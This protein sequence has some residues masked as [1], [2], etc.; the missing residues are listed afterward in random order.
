MTDIDTTAAD[1]PVEDAVAAQ[2]A[3]AEVSPDD[4]ATEAAE[5]RTA[6]E[7]AALRG[8]TDPDDIAAGV[9]QNYADETG[10]EAADAEPAEGTQADAQAAPAD[11]AESGEGTADAKPA[12]PRRARK[13]KAT[14]APPAG[15][16]T[17]P[18]APPAPAVDDSAGRPLTKDEKRALAAAVVTA[19]AA[20]LFGARTPAALKG[21]PS[22]TA[23]QQVANWLAY[24]PAGEQWDDRL[25]K[26][27]NIRK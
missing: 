19:T 11:G 24:L 20:A 4:R 2:D 22:D 16:E 8:E 23:K 12:K 15:A 1:Q 14:D 5:G 27:N 3:A 25:P 10:A 13:A 26:P 18:A 17:P 6:E 9:Q 21:L 7:L